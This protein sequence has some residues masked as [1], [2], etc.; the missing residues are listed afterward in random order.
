[1][2]SRTAEGNIGKLLGD[3]KVIIL[4]GPRQIGKTTL[5]EILEPI[6]PA[7]VLWLNGDDADVRE[8]FT[9]VNVEVL[10]RVVGQNKTLVIDEAQRIRDI[11][12]ALKIIHDR[13]PQVKVLATGSSSFDLA[14]HV[15]EPLTGRKWELQMLPLS[16]REL[17]D[18]FGYIHV[19]RTLE[20]R[21]IYG[22][23][24]E[25]VLHPGTEARRLR[26]LT[27][28]Y[29]YKDVYALE[30]IQKPEALEKILKALAFQVGN[31]VSYNELGQIVG[32]DNQTVEKYVAMLER[33][34]VIFRLPSLNRNLRNELKKSRKIYF[35]DNGIR[36]AVINQFQPLR[37]RKDIGTLWENYMISERMKMI[38]NQQLRVNSYFW[39][40]HN[41][42]EIDY[43][44]E[45]DGQF[46]AFEFKWKPGVSYHF[47][48]DFLNSYEVRSRQIIHQENYDA[49]LTSSD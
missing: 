35:Y 13:I 17:S 12:M 21:L 23:Y 27:D 15:N 3:N 5:V 48:S 6:L 22:S 14:N 2:I 44:E 47:A 36:N 28:S 42:R 25:I 33:T 10:K 29:L 1:M 19:R 43:V 4:Y 9:G 38:A 26:I 45:K 32:L 18:H 39:R 30:K 41:G 37:N 20:D 34:F 16:H 7:P 24:P 46:S 40:N 31:Q 11:G 49:W 8:L